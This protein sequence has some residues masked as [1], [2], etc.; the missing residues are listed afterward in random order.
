MITFDGTYDLF[1][2]YLKPGIF[3]WG[4]MTSE[5]ALVEDA[6]EEAKDAFDKYVERKRKA[7]ERGIRS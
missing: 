6:P 1:S 3:G 4:K 2:K 5:E 7:K